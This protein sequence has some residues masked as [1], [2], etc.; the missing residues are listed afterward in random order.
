MHTL[1]D[2]QN[3]CLN[4]PKQIENRMAIG[5]TRLVEEYVPNYCIHPVRVR[6]SA[7][8]QLQTHSAKL[9]HT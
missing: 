6:I 4:S 3:V 7:P 2:Q 8:S 9:F 1:K 5:I